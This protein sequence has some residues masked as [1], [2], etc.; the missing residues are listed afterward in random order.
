M[1]ETERGKVKR[2]D[3]KDDRQ[4]RERETER[5]SCKEGENDGIT[6]VGMI[7]FGH[8]SIHT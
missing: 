8:V 3:K 6:A 7:Q 4:K 5:R 2:R 1:G